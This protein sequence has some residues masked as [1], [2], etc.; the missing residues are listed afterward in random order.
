[1]IFL[2]GGRVAEAESKRK[3][4]QGRAKDPARRMYEDLFSEEERQALLGAVESADLEGEVALL[5]VLIRRGVAEGV[6]LE[7]L[8]RSIARLAQA[9]RDQHVIRGQSAKNLDEAL[10]RVLEEIGN[11][12]GE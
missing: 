1:M 7:T 8:S 9:M 5:R 11:E 2:R 6:D 4:A 10:A 12:L 3:K